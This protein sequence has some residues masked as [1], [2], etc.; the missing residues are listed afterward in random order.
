[1]DFGLIFFSIF[2]VSSI[3]GARLL[4]PSLIK[5]LLVII[6]KNRLNLALFTAIAGWGLYHL[7]KSYQIKLFYFFTL[8]QYL[9][10]IIFIFFMSMLWLGQKDI[11]LNTL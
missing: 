7:C 4:G 6:L 10:L 11:D 5:I 9:P 2:T 1:M 3:I 8:P